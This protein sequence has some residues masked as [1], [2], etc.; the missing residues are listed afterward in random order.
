MWSKRVSI[1]F[2]LSFMLSGVFAQLSLQEAYIQKYKGIAI[3]EMEKHGIPASIK[4]AQ[5]ILE[6]NS[7]R[8]DLATQAKNHFGIKIS[9]NWTGGLFPKVDDEFDRYGNPI[10]SYFR[11]YRTVEDSYTDHSSWSIPF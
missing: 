10:Q 3:R 1:T 2:I 6:S 7:G 4:L 8:S 11:V 9:S 5:G